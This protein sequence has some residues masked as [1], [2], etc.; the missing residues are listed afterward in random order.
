MG[1]RLQ[2][3]AGSA[4][5]VVVALG[6]VTAK[7]ADPGGGAAPTSEPSSVSEIL[8]VAGKREEKIESVPVAI[9]AFS[10]KQRQLV[11]IK[12]LQDLTDYAPGLSYNASSDRPY[13]RGVGRNTD[14]LTTASAVA[15]YYNGVYYGANAAIVLQKDDLF[16][17][18]VEIDRGPQ[19]TLHGSNADGGTIN[20]ISQKPTSSFYAEGRAGVANYDTYFGEAVVSGPISDNVR[21]RIGGNY[22]DEA[23]GY[24]K[25]FDGPP[26]GGL[27][28]LGAS[29]QSYYT[30]AQLDANVGK[31]DIWGMVSSGEFWTNRPNGEAVG[32]YPDNITTNGNGFQPNSF[33][34]LCGLPGVPATANGAGCAGGPPIVA[35]SVVTGPVTANQ[36]PGNNPGNTNPRQLD[37]KSVV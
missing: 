21:F 26:Q 19:N 2:L 14:N 30:E 7:A 9:T 6:A 23:G 15:T 25:N 32:A 27:I 16:I 5:S 10:A 34:G 1:T 35:G 22:T 28:A 18:T 29:G 24:N 37:R 12:S 36:F 13:I 11:G 3:C 31:L 4:L 8:V 20:Y 33:Y 17:N